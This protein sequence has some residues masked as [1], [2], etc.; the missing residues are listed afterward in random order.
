[1][2][3]SDPKAIRALAHPLRLDLLELLT[4]IGPATAARCGR[5]LGVPQA[6]CSFHLRQLA[7]Y[8]FVEDA[9]PGRDRRERTWRVPAGQPVLRI[10]ADDD[11]LVRRQLERVVVEREMQA[12]LDH[13]ER[14]DAEAPRWRDAQSI[15]SAVASVT[16]AEA[17]ELKER[18]KALLEP[19]I[20]RARAGGGSA[21]EAA[22]R[23]QR[24]IRYFM[25]ATPL[26][27][28]DRGD[29]GDDTDD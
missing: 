4:A 22:G 20:A 15:V 18:W 24:H 7:K 3:I 8:G 5:A 14:R 1:M 2:R 11:P 27:A 26:T 12:I 25:A 16:P 28:L 21:A 10:G 23:E 19:Y 9:G 6:N 13:A 29:H 17:A